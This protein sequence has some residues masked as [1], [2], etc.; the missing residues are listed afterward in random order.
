MVRPLKTI[1]W[2]WL[3]TIN[4]NWFFDSSIKLPAW[5]WIGI[6]VCMFVLAIYMSYEEK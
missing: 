3:L 1:I 6:L 4:T 5:K 2:F